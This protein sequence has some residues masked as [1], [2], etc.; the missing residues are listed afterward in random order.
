MFAVNQGKGWWLERLG[1]I[2]S[3]MTFD[4]DEFFSRFISNDYNS[5][6]NSGVL[7]LGNS[8]TGGIAGGVAAGD[9]LLFAAPAIALA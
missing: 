1:V 3:Y 7:I 4:I 6:L 2:E 5:C 8:R 9:A